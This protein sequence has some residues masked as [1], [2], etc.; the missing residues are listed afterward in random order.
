[1]EKKIYNGYAF[2]ENE[3]EKGKINREIYSELTEKYS[4]YQNDIYFNPDP[5]VNTDNFDV[6]IGR[7]P[8]YAHAEYNIIRNGPGLSTEELLLICDGGNLCFGGRRLSS[9]RLRVSED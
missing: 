4:I 5:E 1:M 9:N 3:R 2:T 8:G 7:K 6:V